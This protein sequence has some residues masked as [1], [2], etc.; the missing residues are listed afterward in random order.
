[1]DC[2]SHGTQPST[3]RFGLL[4][5]AVQ[6]LLMQRQNLDVPEE[7]PSFFGSR[8]SFALKFPNERPLQ[9]YY[10][11]CLFD[12]KAQ[13]REPAVF[14]SGHFT[15]AVIFPMADKGLG[16]DIVPAANKRCLAGSV[17][18]ELFAGA[19]VGAYG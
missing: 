7:E 2:S 18:F 16:P 10:G 8:F 6:F 5:D 13:L 12:A 19:I 4:L 11:L 15:D 1:M 14:S 9:I 3:V 17:R